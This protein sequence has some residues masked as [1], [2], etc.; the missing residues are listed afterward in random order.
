MLFAKGGTI[1]VS[2]EVTNPEYA[3]ED[4]QF[5]VVE[6]RPGR[7]FRSGGD[8]LP[9]IA[10]GARAGLGRHDRRY[11]I[12]CGYSTVTA[13]IPRMR[14]PTSR[15][16]TAA[17]WLFVLP[18]FTA[19]VAKEA[20]K[21]EIAGMAVLAVASVVVTQRMP[22][23]PVERVYLVTAAL[24]LVLIAYLAFG[25]WPSQFGTPRAYDVQALLFIATYAA[26]AVF[27]VLFFD[28]GVFGRVTWQAATAALWIAV[29]CCLASR[30]TG[31]AL[32][33]NP[34]YGTL[35]MQGTLSEPSAWSA[36]LAV[37]LLLAL[38]R[39]SWLYVTLALA[40]LW[41]ADSPSC[42]LV[43]AVVL[44]L[45][46]ALASTW[47][48]RPLLLAMLVV[49]VPVGVFFVQ[50]A[51]P[52]PYL[53]SGNAAKVAAGRLLSGIRNVETGG[54]EG[55]NDHFASAPVVI[56]DARD[57]GWLITGAGPAADVT[58][59]PAKYPPAEGPVIL[60]N[61]LWESVLFDYGE[62]GVVVL[63]V[64]LL[65][66]A[67]RVRRFPEMAAVLLPFMVMSV[68]DSAEGSFGY[69]FT[70]LAV[71]LFA[72]GWTPSGVLSEVRDDQRE[73]FLP[74][75]ARA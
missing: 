2:A 21:I 66:A 30:L 60:P 46:V 42:L 44:P 26:V 6:C 22:P 53:D 74:A 5:G 64:L 35:R 34:I 29:A 72:F 47:K 20:A 61:A 68:T 12:T 27:A 4:D 38:R 25:S 48:H 31:H 9:I 41:L 58:W 45:Y 54:Q 51:N 19:G 75:A 73:P 15:I 17:T 14:T 33:A 1:S 52:Q 24:V 13:S 69:V 49:I 57:G 16:Q 23:R 62:W 10:A 55:S 67:W 50:Q 63:T 40:G 37:V 7:S 65:T 11:A 32:L 28:E 71:M 70:A 8:V 36:P 56:A 59:F 18:F 3:R 39:R 43:I